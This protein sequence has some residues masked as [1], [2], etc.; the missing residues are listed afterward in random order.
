MLNSDD[1]K[2]MERTIDTPLGKTSLTRLRDEVE[3]D[4][5]NASQFG[6]SANDST[7]GANENYNTANDY[8]S[9]GASPNYQNQPMP[10]AP[11]NSQV[12]MQRPSAPGRPLVPP[13]RFN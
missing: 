4:R 6:D 13:Q 12:G 10:V 5:S 7:V 3:A 9:L 11:P 8:S 1:F 2:K